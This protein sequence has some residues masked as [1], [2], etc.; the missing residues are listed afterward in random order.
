MYKKLIKYTD[1]NGAERE[2]DFY[3]NISKSEI[4][5]MDVSE[6]GGIQ[7]RLT[8][9]VQA[10]KGK[11]I[12]EVFEGLILSSYGVRSPDGKS[13]AKSSDISQA[14]KDTA[15]YDVF[16]M[17][18]VTDADAASVFVNAVFPA[19]L[20]ADA[21]KA[22]AEREAKDGFRPG[23]EPA[24]DARPGAAP[25]VNPVISAQPNQNVFDEQAKRDAMEIEIRNKI[26]REQAEA[27]VPPATIHPEV[28]SA[29]DDAVEAQKAIG[30]NPQS[31]GQPGN[32]PQG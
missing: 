29:A 3:F 30:D 7:E 12:M 13:F 10:E 14:F 20:V 28:L 11:E 15:A 32:T 25:G 5:K 23:H 24:T 8:R 18:L 6:D 17:E 19:D 2:E 26:A 9:V 27:N 1:F 16:F 4:V 31:W 22:R 21:D